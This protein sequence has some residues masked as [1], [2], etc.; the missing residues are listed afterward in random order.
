M[1]VSYKIDKQHKLVMSTAF[2]VVTMADALAHQAQLLADVDFD[3]S[4]SQLMD[5]T[6]VTKLEAGPGDIRRLAMETIFS[7][8]S[9]RAIL[10]SSNL[11]YGLARMFEIFRETVGEKGIH[12]FRNLDEALDWVLAKKSAAG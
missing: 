5:L 12:V 7:A 11:V 2:G 1:P 6:H 4:F 9:R 3:P 10:V 8:D